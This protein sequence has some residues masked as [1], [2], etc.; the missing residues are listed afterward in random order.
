MVITTL[1]LGLVNPFTKFIIFLQ[2][3]KNGQTVNQQEQWHTELKQLAERYG[4]VNLPEPLSERA[5]SE[6]EGLLRANSQTNNSQNLFIPGIGI[7]LFILGLILRQPLVWI[8]GIIALHYS[9]VVIDPA[10]Q[11]AIADNC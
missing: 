9:I 4:S 1:R 8:C 2:I 7:V 6:L 3:Q 11:Q 5:V 10:S